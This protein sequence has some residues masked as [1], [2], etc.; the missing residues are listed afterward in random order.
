HLDRVRLQYAGAGD[1]YAAARAARFYTSE[2]GRAGMVAAFVSDQVGLNAAAPGRGEWPGRGGVNVLQV[3]RSL[4][5]PED[6]WHMVQTLRYDF[7]NG[8][9]HYARGANTADHISFLGT[10]FRKAPSGAKEPFY[11][12]EMNPRH[13]EDVVAAIREGKMRSDFV[14]FAIHSHHF[15]DA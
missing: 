15:R 11:S 14:T 8:T 3:N 1:T 6:R 5:V 7:P 13:F 9:S 12:F 4:M 10:S 2:R